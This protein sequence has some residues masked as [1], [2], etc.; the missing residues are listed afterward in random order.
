MAGSHREPQ[1]ASGAPVAV[2]S[3]SALLPPLWRSCSGPLWSQPRP[4]SS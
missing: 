1:R 4:P 2:I 3:R